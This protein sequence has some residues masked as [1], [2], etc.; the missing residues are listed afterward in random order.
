VAFRSTGLAIE[1]VRALVA[2]HPAG[3]AAHALGH[4]DV[5]GGAKS[6]HI[7]AGLAFVNPMP[8]VEP[9]RR[10]SAKSGQRGTRPWLI[11]SGSQPHDSRRTSAGS[12][13]SRSVGWDMGFAWD[14]S[15][16]PASAPMRPG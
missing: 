6:P 9:P 11:G 7:R 16:R 13:S 15:R 3:G 2:S 10:T 4:W 8:P 1:L 14:R 12:R 5:T